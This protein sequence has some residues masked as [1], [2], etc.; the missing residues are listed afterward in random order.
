MTTGGLRILI[1]LMY[2]VEDIVVHSYTVIISH[3]ILYPLHQPNV[4]KR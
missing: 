2:L 4:A 3:M 1:F